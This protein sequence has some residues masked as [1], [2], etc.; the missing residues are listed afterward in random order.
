VGLKE[1]E[2]KIFVVLMIGRKSRTWHC[3]KLTSLP[4]HPHISGRE[5]QKWY[6]VFTSFALVVLSFLVSC[7]ELIKEIFVIYYMKKDENTE[8]LWPKM[9]LHFSETDPSADGCSQVI[10]FDQSFFTIKVL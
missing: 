6:S 1:K 2:W 8:V 7:K 3:A 4:D 9:F 5:F 10:L